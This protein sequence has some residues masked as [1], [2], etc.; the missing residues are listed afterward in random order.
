MVRSQTLLLV[1]A[2]ERKRTSASTLTGNEPGI[3]RCSGLCSAGTR[4]AVST[5]S[6]G[7]SCDRERRGRPASRARAGVSR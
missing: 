2:E 3:D 7:C 4:R 1:S 6:A 5:A